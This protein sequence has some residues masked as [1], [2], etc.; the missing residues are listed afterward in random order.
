MSILDSR[1]VIDYTQS[2]PCCL[3][4]IYV[5]NFSIQ[6][7]NNICA[8][9]SCLGQLAFIAK[10]IGSHRL[11]RGFKSFNGFFLL[12]L[13]ITLPNYLQIGTNLHIQNLNVYVCL[14]YEFR[15]DFQQNVHTDHLLCMFTQNIAIFI[16]L[17]GAIQICHASNLY[18]IAHKFSVSF[19][20][21]LRIEFSRWCT[22]LQKLIQIYRNLQ[23]RI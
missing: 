14:L 11:G 2:S 18:G 4:G 9:S 23:K 1:T 19:C 3:C 20:M 6:H 17:Y 13:F 8:R 15:M 21:S 5:V 22:N 10:A 12:S 16:F 7:N